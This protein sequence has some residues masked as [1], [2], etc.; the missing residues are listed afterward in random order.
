MA[1]KILAEQTS[2]E[3]LDSLSSLSTTAALS[4]KK[5]KELND[6]LNNVEG[7]GRFLSLWDCTAGTPET[8]PPSSPYAYKSGD[9]YEVSKVGTTNYMPDTTVYTT[10]LVSTTVITDTVHVGD[11][12][13]FDGT[14]WILRAHTPEPVNFENIQGEVEDNA[15]L[16][17]ALGAKQDTITAGAGIQKT[18][19]T[20]S[21]KGMT[22]ATG[23]LAGEAG[24]VPAP[25][26]G[27]NEKFLKGDGTWGTVSAGVTVT[28]NDSTKTMEFA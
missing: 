1:E 5:G 15:K 14:E 12:F 13:K 3:I 7:L 25:S 24:M 20:L 6:R 16:A 17:E 27:D 9:Y 21:A 2:V 26:S 18:G 19:S 22:G 10:G 23:A 28:Y 4:A 11:Y 8:E